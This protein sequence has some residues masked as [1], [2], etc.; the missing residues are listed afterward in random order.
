MPSFAW[1]HY[2]IHMELHLH[3]F[4]SL[5]ITHAI[6]EAAKYWGRKKLPGKTSWCWDQ[7]RRLS[8]E[9]LGGKFQGRTSL[10]RLHLQIFKFDLRNIIWTFITNL[11]LCAFSS[12]DNCWVEEVSWNLTSLKNQ[13]WWAPRKRYRWENFYLRIHWESHLHW[14]SAAQHS[15]PMRKCRKRRRSKNGSV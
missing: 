10:L 8:D 6:A 3:R 9:R 7:F 14:H 15:R 13:L 11:P 12:L 1:N 4:H 5:G 2:Y